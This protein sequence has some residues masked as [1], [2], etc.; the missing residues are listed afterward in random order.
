MVVDHVEQHPEAEA[1][2][3]VDQAA[4][5]A[6]ALLRFPHERDTEGRAFRRA[7]STGR[8]SGAWMERTDATSTAGRRF[9]TANPAEVEQVL[10][11]IVRRA[12]ALVADH[13][14]PGPDDDEELALAQSLAASAR[15]A[16]STLHRPED[17]DGDT[18]PERL[19]LPTRRKARIA[20]LIWMPRWLSKSTSGI[21]S[22]TSAATCCVPRSRSSG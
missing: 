5:V 8:R 4:Q 10:A 18:L 2:G 19:W 21:D 13:D 16:P 7:L 11:R 3:L 12:T 14:H 1:V 6:A 9:F 15:S 20:R 22:S 17:A